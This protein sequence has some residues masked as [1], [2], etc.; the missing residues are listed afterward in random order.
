MSPLHRS[1]GEEDDVANINKELKAD[2]KINL[3]V[4]TQVNILICFLLINMR[5]FKPQ[6]HNYFRVFVLCVDYPYT[7]FLQLETYN[8][9]N[10]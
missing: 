10:K 9:T 1:I 8:T 7:Q 2:V 5:T 4:L 6:I 3:E